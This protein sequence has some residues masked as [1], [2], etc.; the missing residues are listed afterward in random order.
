MH[1]AKYKGNQTGA[2]LAHDSRQNRNYGNK[3]IDR[4][5]SHQNYNLAPDRDR[6]PQEYLAQRIEEVKHLNRADVVRM[7]SVA[8]TLP[9]DYEEHSREFFQVAYNALADRYGGEGERN[10]IGAFIHRDETRDHMHFCFAPIVTDPDGRERLCCKEIVNREDLRT[11]H[12]DIER[13]VNR[14]LKERDLP[15]ISLLN[16]A[17][18]EHGYNRDFRE[19]KADQYERECRDL[20]RKI[21]IAKDQAT[22]FISREQERADNAA[23]RVNDY[24][25]QREKDLA[26]LKKHVEP[27][28]GFLGRTDYKAAFE[29]ECI[30]HDHTK[31]EKLIIAD[32][33]RELEDRCRD[34]ENRCIDLSEKARNADKNRQ[35]EYEERLSYQD[36]WN[37]RDALEERLRELDREHDRDRD[38]DRDLD[39]HH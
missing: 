34:L 18:R 25:A 15:P 3:E 6:S 29:K 26:E 21:D 22:K 32:R 4:D 9:R 19:F 1:I 38:R 28:K 37:D 20:E 35:L 12:T 8:V 24:I 14:E 30:E 16:G 17:V 33:Y 11:L 23:D 7:V 10:V 27:Q 5:R 13:A 36:K 31:A 2:L 39:H